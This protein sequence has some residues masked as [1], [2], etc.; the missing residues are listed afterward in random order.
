[1][2]IPF[3]RVEIVHRGGRHGLLG[4]H[5]QRVA[6]NVQRLKIARRH[7]FDAGRDADDL[8]AGD[9]VE[10]GVRYPADLM[11]GTP[12]PLQAGRNRQRRRNLDHQIDRTHIDA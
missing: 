11:I 10:Q 4:Q 7:A 3:V 1:M 6:G 2:R 8:P 9:R 5:I 12:H